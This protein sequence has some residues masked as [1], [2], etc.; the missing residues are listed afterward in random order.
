[1]SKVV[2]TIKCGTYYN[3]ENDWVIQ[4]LLLQSSLMN[5]KVMFNSK[6]ID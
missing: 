1:M 4:N 5:L 3:D 2:N 6:E